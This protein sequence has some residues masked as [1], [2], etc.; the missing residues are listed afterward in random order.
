M[1]HPIDCDDRLEEARYG[2]GLVRPRS[3]IISKQN[4]VGNFIR[5]TVELRPAAELPDQIQEARMKLG[6]G[7]RAKREPRPASIRCCANDCVVE[8]IEGDLHA[9]SAVRDYGS[10]EALC[11]DV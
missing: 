3:P 11:V 10:R 7:H 9:R 6:N 1:K 4:G 2:V 5:A 8:K